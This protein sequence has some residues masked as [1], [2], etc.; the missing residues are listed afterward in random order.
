M[1]IS[2]ILPLAPRSPLLYAKQ[3]GK[4]S[5]SNMERFTKAL[6]IIDT[7]SIIN[8]DKITLAQK[9][10]LEYL[11]RFFDIRVCETI[12]DEFLRHRDLVVSREASYWESFLSSRRH[13]PQTLIDDQAVLEPFYS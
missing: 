7:C 10:V 2:R 5:R 11:R 3:L 6:C 1:Y 4:P 9:V 13:R 12:K 8:L